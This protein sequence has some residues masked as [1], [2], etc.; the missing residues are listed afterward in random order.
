MV[1]NKNMFKCV[2]FTLRARG[3]EGSKN[4]LYGLDYEYFLTAYTS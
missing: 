2:L 3:K 4:D 1:K